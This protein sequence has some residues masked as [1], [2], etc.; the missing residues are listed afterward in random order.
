MKES[1]VNQV[2]TCHSIVGVQLASQHP[3]QG[4]YLPGKYHRPLVKLTSHN[5]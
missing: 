5:K 4:V 2:L 1:I 3:T